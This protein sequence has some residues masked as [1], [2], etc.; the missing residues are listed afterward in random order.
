MGMTPLLTMV[1]GL[2][3]FGPWVIE[4]SGWTVPQGGGQEHRSVQ[5]EGVEPCG[6]GGLSPIVKI[7]TQGT[8][9]CQVPSPISSS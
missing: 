1:M 3:I 8:G 4:F 9:V 2:R 6:M 7:I 5:A